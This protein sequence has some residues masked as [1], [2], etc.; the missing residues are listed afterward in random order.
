MNSTNNIIIQ[1]LL[2]M[3]EKTAKCSGFVAGMVSQSWV[4]RMLGDKICEY[5]GIPYV[6]EKNSDGT[7]NMVRAKEGLEKSIEKSEI[8]ISKIDF[9]QLACEIIDQYESDRQES[10]RKELVKGMKYVLEKYN[11]SHDREIVDEML[12]TFTG[13]K[14]STLVEMSKTQEYDDED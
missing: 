3:Q 4:I 8:D 11:N 1:E 7:W 12:I 5:G 2:L 14:L 13:Y 9:E 6:L 10:G